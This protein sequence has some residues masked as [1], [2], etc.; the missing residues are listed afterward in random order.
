[1]AVAAASAA[2]VL[3]VPRCVNSI[4]DPRE[5]SYP[6]NTKLLLPETAG[7]RSEDA[8]AGRGRGGRARLALARDVQSSVTQVFGEDTSRTPGH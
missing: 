7:V 8:R 6:A 1:M 2:A 4:C 5:F 3:S